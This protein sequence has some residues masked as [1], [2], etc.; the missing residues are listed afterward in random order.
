MHTRQHSICVRTP[1][2]LKICPH[3]RNS[4]F[5]TLR[6][7]GHSPFVINDEEITFTD[8]MPLYDLHESDV[9]SLISARGFFTVG[10]SFL[11]PETNCLWQGTVEF[12]GIAEKVLYRNQGLCYKGYADDLLICINQ[13]SVHK[14][15]AYKFTN[16]YEGK[17]F[18]I[19]SYTPVMFDPKKSN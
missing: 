2:S 1:H 15:D 7:D 10:L 14:L 19:D 6:K 13:N 8:G 11:H 17:H 16:I 4:L 12:S 5:Y 3:T 9:R 18:E